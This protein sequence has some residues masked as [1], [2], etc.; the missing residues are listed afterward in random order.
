MTTSDRCRAALTA[1]LGKLQPACQ[2][3]PEYQQ[4]V[5]ETADNL[6]PSI[7]SDLYVKEYERGAGQELAWQTG[8]DRRRPPKFHAAFSSAALTVNAFAPWKRSP[9]LLPL[10]GHVGFSTLTFEQTCPTGLRGT[11][12]HAD[13][14]V[15]NAT[16]VVGVESKCLEFL[17]LERADFVVSYDRIRGLAAQT[18]Y[19]ALIRHLRAFPTEFGRLGVG[20]LIKH[21]LGLATCFPEQQIT[22]LYLFW[23]PT[24][25]RE[26]SEFREH[27]DEIERFSALVAADTVAFKAM[28]YSDLWKEWDLVEHPSWVHEHVSALRDRYDVMI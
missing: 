19:Y 2:W 9:T 3:V 24:N 25:W 10:L 27:R 7:S 17:S 8:P 22:L 23:E 28:T 4:Y 14:L 16:R 13:V 15:S 6:L 21:A 1:R 18:K 20:Q 26:F 5:C 11:P 12:P